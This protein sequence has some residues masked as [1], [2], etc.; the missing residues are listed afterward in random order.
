[1]SWVDEKLCDPEMAR[2]VIDEF[3]ARLY[4][5]EAERD[6]AIAR[7]ELAASRLDVSP[8]DA[9][10]AARYIEDSDEEIERDPYGL[11]RRFRS[12]VYPYDRVMD[13]LRAHAAK[14]SR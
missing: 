9:L 13:A 5:S 8:E 3:K 1:M 10:C 12:D 11:G 7:A 6:S 2:A 4:A 14:V